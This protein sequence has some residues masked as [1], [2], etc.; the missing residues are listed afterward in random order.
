MSCN[1]FTCSSIIE[2]SDDCF[3]C[4]F[5][6]ELSKGWECLVGGGDPCVMSCAAP[7][8]GQFPPWNKDPQL[9][10][11]AF[12]RKATSCSHSVP[13]SLSSGVMHAG[14]DILGFVTRVSTSKATLST[15][16]FSMKYLGVHICHL[17]IAQ[18]KMTRLWICC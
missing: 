17:T 5:P 9:C 3:F 11:L 2:H 7:P 8:W 6:K 15:F 16:Y 13:P 10:L 4:T 1:L 18:E 14:L 12:V